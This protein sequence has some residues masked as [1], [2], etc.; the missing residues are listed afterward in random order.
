MSREPATPKQIAYL[1]FMG[2][3]KADRLTKDKASQ[4]IESL[5]DVSDLREYER[6]EK[7]KSEWIRQRFILH[8]DLYS[9]E[10]KNFFIHELP[11]TLHNFVRS[12]MTGASEKLTKTKI[13]QVVNALGREDADWWKE[14]NFKDAFWSKLQ[15]MHP[16]CCDGQ[17]KERKKKA[18][19]KRQQAARRAPAAKPSGS[20]C[21]VTIILILSAVAAV[22]AMMK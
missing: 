22:A 20:G 1:T 9:Y 14:A 11:E 7:R 19:A 3:P 17:L 15:E 16:G 10:L 18:P 8:P 21:L 13:R 12:R 6:V 4:A 2:Y 5:S